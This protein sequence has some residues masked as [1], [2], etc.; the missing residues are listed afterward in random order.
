MRL[1]RRLSFES[2][3]S[4]RL[5]AVVDI[6]DDLQ[7]I[8]QQQ[9]ASPVNIDNAAGIRGAE[10]RLKYDPSVLDINAAQIV[11]GSV[12]GN[13]PNVQVVA[14][15]DAANGLISVFIFGADGLPAGSGS[16]VNFNFTVR[17][18]ATVGS[19]TTLDL[20][21]VRLNEGGIPVTPEPQTGADATDGVIT[22]GGPPGGSG[23]ISG[24]VFADSNLNNQIDAHEGIPA[25]TI[26]LVNTATSVQ[27]Q[28]TTSASGEFQFTDVAPGTYRIQQKQ[29]VAFIN[30]GPN[31]ISVTIADG[32]GLTEQNFREIGLKPEY[33]YSRLFTTLVMPVGSTEWTN[34]IERIVTDAENG[35]MRAI[36][37]TAAP[38]N[39]F[40]NSLSN[41]ASTATTSTNDSPSAENSAGEFTETAFASS[42]PQSAGEATESESVDAA[43]LIAPDSWTASES[44][45]PQLPDTA[46]SI[47]ST[48]DDEL[49]LALLAAEDSG[50][51]SSLDE[52][53]V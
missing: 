30:G 1:L 31:E 9:V 17:A 40:D 5:L 33:V 28:V 48:D 15:V 38:A 35:I 4:R 32:Q 24:R 3:E 29:P 53:L 8:P 37:V 36:N 50:T 51:D 16:L 21:E 52:L 23:T 47:P 19:T 10:I 6:P 22:I 46:E 43:M 11:K 41:V 12:W 27:T 49:M 44:N 42:P 34:T 25:V 20:T 26:T 45:D 14:N 7:G 13:D 2:M 39:S 18:G